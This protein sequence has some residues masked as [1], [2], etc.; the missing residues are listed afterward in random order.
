MPKALVDKNKAPPEFSKV[1]VKCT[2]LSMLRV[3]AVLCEWTRFL[4]IPH[5]CQ[6]LR[7]PGLTTNKRRL[8]ASWLRR[9]HTAVLGL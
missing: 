5:A 2:L 1:V 4:C 3:L 9:W 7:T 8:D 6:N